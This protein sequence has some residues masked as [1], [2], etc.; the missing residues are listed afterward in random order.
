MSSKNIIF[1]KH[2]N[3]GAVDAIDDSIYLQTCFVDTGELDILR[4]VQDPKCLI[5]GRVGTGKT[6]LIEILKNKEER[7]SVINPDELSISY[8]SNDPYLREMISAG[9]N[10]GLFFRYL[11]KHVLIIQILRIHFDLKPEQ[12]IFSFVEQIQKLKFSNKSSEYA[13]EY[14]LKYAH[15]FW[16]RTDET[17]KEVT[18]EYIDNAGGKIQAGASNNG[19]NASLTIENNSLNKSSQKS[20]VSKTGKDFFDSQQMETISH[21]VN[22]LGDELLVDKAKKIFICIDRLDDHWIDDELKY[23]LI[24]ALIESSREINNKLIPVKVIIS[25]REDLLKKV[26]DTVFN[27]TDQIEKYESLYIK[28]KW[29]KEELRDVVNRRVNQLMKNQY[30]N[31]NV[32]VEEILP[33]N[34]D[35]QDGLN[36]LIS[37]TLQTP[38]D[39]VMLF[40]SCLDKS[41]GHTNISIDNIKEAE[42]YYSQDRLD[43][44][45]TE[46]IKVFPDIKHYLN[47]LYGQK[48]IFKLTNVKWEPLEVNILNYMVEHD[49]YKDNFYYWCETYTSKPKKDFLKELLEVCYTVGVIGYSKELTISP[50]WSFNG[51]GKF[52]GDRLE[53]YFFIVH[54]AFESALNLEK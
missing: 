27:Q 26:F 23:L 18:R 42:Y 45:V 22:I 44:I 3:I 52:L 15:Q 14:L 46:W 21:V 17:V 25:L 33:E 10:V 12:K 50:A 31:S 32:S 24:K 34:V 5:L 54:P 38:R 36:Y 39:V 6:A 20:E 28:L 16:K 4:N 29:E 30:T 19:I 2:A 1:K 43:Y 13:R 9:Y 37:R 40:N 51:K 11:W 47:L 41:V 7:I 35:N 48:N 8:L 49:H 53:D